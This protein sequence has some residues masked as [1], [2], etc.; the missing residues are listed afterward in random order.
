MNKTLLTSICAAALTSAASAF[1]L[2]LSP[3]NGSSSGVLTTQL[4][5]FTVSGPND[6]SNGIISLDNTEQFTIVYPSTVTYFGALIGGSVI[7]ADDS[8]TLGS[9]TFIGTEDGATVTTITFDQVPEPSSTALLGLGGLAL[10]L[11]RRK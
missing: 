8:P 6:I 4:G 9:V 5:D 7:T 3:L 1:T 11:R 2:D 10:I